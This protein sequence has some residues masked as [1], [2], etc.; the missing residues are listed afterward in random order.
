MS[1]AQT[2]R[3]V[4]FLNPHEPSLQTDLSWLAM[5][6][7][8]ALVNAQVSVQWQVLAQPIAGGAA[9]TGMPAPLPEAHMAHMAQYDARLAD[10][11][12]LAQQTAVELGREAELVLAVTSPEWWAPVLAH[13]PRRMAY[14][15]RHPHWP[16]RVLGSLC[17][18]CDEVWVPDAPFAQDLR[19]E[20]AALAVAVMPPIRLHRASLNLALDRVE[21]FQAS[22]GLSASSMVFLCTLDEGGLPTCA[23][24]LAAWSQAFGGRPSTDVALV[25]HCPPRFKLASSPSGFVDAEAWVSEQLAAAG[26]VQVVLLDQHLNGD[27]EDLLRACT[28]VQLVAGP[29]DGLGL[30][31]L[32]AVDVGNGVVGPA[33]HG[34]EALLGDAWQGFSPGALTQSAGLVQV[35]VAAHEQ[36]LAQ[37]EQRAMTQW[38]VSNHLSEAAFVQ[39]VLAHLPMLEVRA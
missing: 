16:M 22:L 24:L 11:P 37:G 34:L 29:G 6:Q 13:A 4:S 32:D 21:A 15:A 10:L 1:A 38:H 17:A 39:R 18:G 27:G 9:P 31:V 33:L 26:P 35:L 5:R 3:I 2:L 23:H 36:V 25:L 14:L 7:V 30:R 28:Q 20:R 8:R 19:A 12:A